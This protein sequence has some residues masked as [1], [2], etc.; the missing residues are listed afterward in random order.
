METM[1]R[2][3]DYVERERLVMGE[4]GAV[5]V[6][7]DALVEPEQPIAQG[8][9]P[10]AP[11]LAGLRGKVARVIP[12]RGVVVVGVATVLRGLAGFGRSAVGPLIFLPG[13]SAMPP[14]LPPGAIGIVIGELT[15]D[16]LNMAMAARLA[17]I[18]AASAHPTL[19]E[20]LA[21][22]DCTALLDGTVPPTNALPLGIILAHGFGSRTLKPEFAQ[23]L[24]AYNGQ[25]VFLNPAPNGL[26]GQQAELLLPL[27]WQ[28]PPRIERHMVL[29]PGMAV[30]VVGGEQQGLS[31]RVVRVLTTAQPFPSGIRAPAA[32]VRL[33]DQT[34]VTLP[35]TNLQRVG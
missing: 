24:A 14:L 16:L 2:P 34:E 31:G 33:E 12:E 25:T 28:T 15:R 20:M 10:S 9:L 1:L 32:R 35:L 13:P 7:V 23:F 4:R 3:A 5:L 27:P 21:G 11:L 26:V 29:Q 22:T 6:G 19:I 18:F 8:A 17:G 30:W